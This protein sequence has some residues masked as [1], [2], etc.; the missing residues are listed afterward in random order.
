MRTN[1]TQAFDDATAEINNWRQ[2]LS[3]SPVTTVEGPDSG[4]GLTPD[5]ILTNARF[6]NPEELT[7]TIE[8][9]L[10]D[11]QKH[12]EFLEKIDRKK[13]KVIEAQSFMKTWYALEGL[14][15]LLKKL[16]PANNES[17]KDKIAAASSRIAAIASAGLSLYRSL[18]AASPHSRIYEERE[19]KAQKS[20]AAGDDTEHSEQAPD[21]TKTSSFSA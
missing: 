13:Q 18:I 21:S 9:A 1:M 19:R 7:Q 11:A 3:K 12:I 5:S 16:V 14:L 6:P 10:A 17:T 8:N 15:E 20:K 2:Q 4:L